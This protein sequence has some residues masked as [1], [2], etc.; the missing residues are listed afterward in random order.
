MRVDCN[1]AIVLGD[2]GEVHWGMDNGGRLNISAKSLHR[3][4]ASLVLALPLEELPLP[5]VSTIASC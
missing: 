1:T 3:S 4:W 2:L 5:L